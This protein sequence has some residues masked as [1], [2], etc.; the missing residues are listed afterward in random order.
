MM[1]SLSGSPMRSSISVSR[2]GTRVSVSRVIDAGAD[3]CV[4]T[5]DASVVDDENTSES[6]QNREERGQHRTASSS[7]LYS[8]LLVNR[9]VQ[10]N[11][12]YPRRCANGKHIPEDCAQSLP[13]VTDPS[14]MGAAILLREGIFSLSI[15]YDD[16]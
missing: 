15:S 8:L 3:G 1:P 4:G 11:Q 2:D 13:L 9:A 6:D 16:E 7:L 14:P 5:A 10:T 12:S